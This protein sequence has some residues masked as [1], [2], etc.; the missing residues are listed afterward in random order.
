MVVAFTAAYA[1]CILALAGAKLTTP[2]L[3][4]L[5]WAEVIYGPALTAACA[6]ALTCLA[7]SVRISDGRG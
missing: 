1:L 3:E 4:P 2:K 7:S 6:Y 5:P